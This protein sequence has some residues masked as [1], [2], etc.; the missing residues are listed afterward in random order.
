[1]GAKLKD[2]TSSSTVTPTTT[3]TTTTTASDKIPHSALPNQVLADVKSHSGKP[4]HV[5]HVDLAT[6]EHSSVPL[7]RV[8]GEPSLLEKATAAAIYVSDQL[9]GTSAPVQHAS[10]SE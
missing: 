5:H 6:V 3:C 1:M 7:G 10:N 8:V 9:T 4:E 2:M